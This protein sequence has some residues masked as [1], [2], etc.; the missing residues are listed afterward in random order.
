MDFLFYYKG[1]HIATKI[2]EW[3]FSA[4]GKIIGRYIASSDIFVDLDGYYI[5]Q[6]PFAYR[7][8]T[9]EVYSFDGI[10]FGAIEYSENIG[11]IGDIG[12]IGMLEKIEGFSDVVKSRLL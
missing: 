9:S 8:L 12:E 7:L 5:G 3:M 6:V 2:N 4:K 10:S 1:I 11:N